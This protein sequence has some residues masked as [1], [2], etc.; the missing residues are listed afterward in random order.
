MFQHITRI[1]HNY[2]S[3]LLWRRG[4]VEMTLNIVCF[5]GIIC[6]RQGNVTNAVSKSVQIY[7]RTANIMTRL[8]EW[9]GWPG[10]L[11]FVFAPKLPRP[12]IWINYVLFTNLIKS[13]KF[14]FY[15]SETVLWGSVKYNNIFTAGV[16]E[17]ISSCITLA[18]PI[19]VNMS[20]EKQCLTTVLKII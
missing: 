16:M 10:L 3:T 5:M 20:A 8:F 17:M 1:T 9:T 15:E 4:Y 13:L 14:R 7:R 11:L 2:V 19:N 6:G 12:S 18:R